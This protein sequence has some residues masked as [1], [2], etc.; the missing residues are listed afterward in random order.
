MSANAVVYDK[1]FSVTTI[2]NTSFKRRSQLTLIDEVT[3]CY[4]QS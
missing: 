4:I 2:Y 1:I 3:D